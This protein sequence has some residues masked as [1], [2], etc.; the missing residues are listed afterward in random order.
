MHCCYL[1]VGSTEL[2]GFV[3][4]CMWCGSSP[5]DRCGEEFVKLVCNCFGFLDE[6]SFLENGEISEKLSNILG[7]HLG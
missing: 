4:F 3:A 6:T 7:D 5:V 2:G 1:P